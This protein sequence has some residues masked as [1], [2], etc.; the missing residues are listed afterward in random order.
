MSTNPLTWKLDEEFATKK[1]NKGGIGYKFAFVEQA[2]D[3]QNH[4]GVL[5]IN[6]PYIKGR[7]FIRLKVW[8]I[9]DINLF[10]MNIRENV[11]LRL[12]NY[13]KQQ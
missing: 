10:W 8:H 3:A 7:F 6:K 4:Q 1:L 13:F 9:A 5:W 12:E 2:A 11:A